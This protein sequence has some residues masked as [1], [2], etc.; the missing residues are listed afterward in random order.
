MTQKQYQNAV[1]AVI[2]ALAEA[3][4]S[5]NLPEKLINTVKRFVWAMLD[6]QFRRFVDE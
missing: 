4:E 3:L 5:Y 2:G 1:D 6:K